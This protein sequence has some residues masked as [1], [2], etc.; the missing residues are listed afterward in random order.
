[1]SEKPFKGKVALVTGSARGIGRS[2]AEDLAEWGADQVILDVKQED[3]DKTAA[4]VSSQFGVKAVGIACNVTNKEQVGAAA[5]KIKAEFGGLNFLVNNAGILR[6]NLLIRMKEEEWDLVL[7]VN[8]KGPFLVTQGMLRMLMKA[9]GGGR[10]VNISSVSGLVGQA[11]QA[12]YSS[13]KSGLIGF[14]KVVARE[15]AS[16]GLLCNAICPG[17]VQTDLTG[18]LTEEVQEMLKQSIPLGRPGKV[19]DISRVV[20]FLCSEDASFITGNILR[21]DGGTAI[22]M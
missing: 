12:N 19:E 6:D 7:D 11:G 15:Y 22:G 3:C 9:E 8:L 1:M 2:I 21:V 5:D 14:T 16:K 4:E 10:I 20:R 13:S 18:S 17:Y